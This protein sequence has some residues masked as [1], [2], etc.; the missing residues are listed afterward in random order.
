MLKEIILYDIVCY[1]YLCEYM[2]STERDIVTADNFL[3]H[4]I[5]LQ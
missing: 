3:L 1:S 4:G 2:R 5:H